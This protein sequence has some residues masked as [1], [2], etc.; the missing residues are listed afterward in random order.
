MRAAGS[1]R[2]HPATE[3]AG[4][5]PMPVPRRAVGGDW[6]EKKKKFLTAQEELR[7]LEE[8]ERVEKRETEGHSD[9][10]EEEE[11]D[12]EQE[13]TKGVPPPTHADRQ[14]EATNTN[15]N[16]DRLYAGMNARQRKLAELQQRMKQARKANESAV[17]TEKRKE[18]DGTSGWDDASATGASAAAKNP[19]ADKK[20][21]EERMKKKEEERKRLGLP[22]EKAYL[23][24]TAE[25]AEAK[26][27]K[28][29]GNRD[30]AM[31]PEYE[32]LTERILDAGPGVKDA[33]EAAKAAQDPD[34]Y[35][36]AD[37]LAYGGAGGASKEGLD[38]MVADLEERQSGARVARRKRREMS[39]I[40][41][42]ADNINA[43]NAFYNRKIDISLGKFSA[44]I[45]ANLE[46]GTALPDR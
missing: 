26:A 6:G 16:K 19:A 41:R 43:S 14:D 18:A 45:K 3:A 23:L 31:D 12:E 30:E 28:K 1:L 20:W 17:V 33:Y 11:D 42:G 9:Q 32:R 46:R 24:E 39:A 2:G 35:R 8:K 21:Y 15:T 25:A 37:S 10:D 5:P 44:E 40:E 38:R 22:E 27:L 7:A 36:T 34:F 4:Q 29:R 13:G